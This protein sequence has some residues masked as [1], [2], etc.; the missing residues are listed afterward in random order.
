MLTFMIIGDI[1]KSSNWLST[2]GW[3][4]K[5]LSK[6]IFAKMKIFCRV[7]IAV[8]HQSIDLCFLTLSTNCNITLFLWLLFFSFSFLR[9]A[10]VIPYMI[11][12]LLDTTFKP[13]SKKSL[14]S[15]KIN[16]SLS[17]TR[18]NA[19]V[20]AEQIKLMLTPTPDAVLVLVFLWQWSTRS[21]RWSLLS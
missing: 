10:D 6:M 7:S 18:L 1:R 9:F 14:L 13:I 2:M 21:G 12:F 15:M 11:S 20:G 4:L 19:C 5:Y 8:Q 3:R 17:W 16:Q